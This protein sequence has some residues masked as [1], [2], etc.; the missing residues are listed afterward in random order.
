[1][2]AQNPPATNSNLGKEQGIPESTRMM[3]DGSHSAEAL[4]VAE[5]SVLG[6]AASFGMVHQLRFGL[7]QMF[8][9]PLHQWHEAGSEV[10]F[11]PSN[12]VHTMSISLM[13]NNQ[14]SS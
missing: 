2:I 4:E 12:L 14:A 5:S 7:G 11:V 6:W 10:S 8:V 3:Q 1:M 9:N 13:D